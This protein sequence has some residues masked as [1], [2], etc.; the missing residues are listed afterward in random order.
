MNDEL[1]RVW[2]ETTMTQLLHGRPTLFSR[3]WHGDTEENHKK[4]VRMASRVSYHCTNQLCV[5]E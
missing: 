4:T 2:K 3:V 5:N 1:E